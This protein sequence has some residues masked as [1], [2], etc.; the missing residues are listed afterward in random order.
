MITHASRAH[1]LILA[2]VVGWWTMAACTGANRRSPY[3][4]DDVEEPIHAWKRE[5]TRRSTRRS[6]QSSS[7]SLD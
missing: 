4:R 6:E 3:A 7:V 2:R 5:W 1:Q